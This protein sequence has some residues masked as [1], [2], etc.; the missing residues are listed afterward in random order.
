M[1]VDLLI[2]E[3]GVQEALALDEGCYAGGEPGYYVRAHSDKLYKFDFVPVEIR[4]KYDPYTVW[5]R[6]SYQIDSDSSLMVT[7]TYSLLLASLFFGLITCV[8]YQSAKR[9][10]GEEESKAL[11]SWLYI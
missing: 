9:L 7:I 3:N 10:M 1:T 6:S 2:A 8:S 5:A 11:R 4:S